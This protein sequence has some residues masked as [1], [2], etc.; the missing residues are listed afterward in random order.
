MLTLDDVLTLAP[1]VVASESDGEQVVV[2]PEQGKFIVLNQTG[3]DVFQSIDGHLS[4]RA[5]AAALSERHD[6]PLAQ[7][8][9]DVLAF[10]GELHK[11]GAALPLETGSD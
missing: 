5:I 11:R 2:L 4:L 3:A 10:A 6:V 1:G 8:E 7:V 9:S